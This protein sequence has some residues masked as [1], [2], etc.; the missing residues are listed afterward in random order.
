MFELLCLFSYL[1]VYIH[2]L[3]LACYYFSP[4][5]SFKTFESALVFVELQELLDICVDLFVVSQL[6]GCTLLVTLLQ[7]YHSI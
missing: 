2:L 5:F 3:L 7:H 1:R 4:F 6:L